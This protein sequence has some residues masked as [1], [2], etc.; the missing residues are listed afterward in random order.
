MDFRVTRIF[1]VNKL[2]FKT[3]YQYKNRKYDSV[4]IAYGKIRI[5]DQDYFGIEFLQRDGLGLLISKTNNLSNIPIYDNDV[6]MLEAKL[7]F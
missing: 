6:V 7:N 3:F 4:W 1:P 5:F 2:T